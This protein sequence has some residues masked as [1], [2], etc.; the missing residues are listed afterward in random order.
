MLPFGFLFVFPICYEHTLRDNNI[1]V[2]L[3]MLSN[4]LVLILRR[5]GTLLWMHAG[6]YNNYYLFF[7]PV[8]RFIYLC[9]FFPLFFATFVIFFFIFFFAFLRAFDHNQEEKTCIDFLYLF[10]YI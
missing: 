7:S 9:F 8:I 6:L 10:I 1:D 5:F 2:Y 3:Y 4:F